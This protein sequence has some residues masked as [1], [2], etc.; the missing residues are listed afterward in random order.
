M[1]PSTS[2]EKVRKSL[3]PK[4]RKCFCY[5]S[6]KVGIILMAVTNTIIH[7]VSLLMLVMRVL[8]WSEIYQLKINGKLNITDVETLEQSYD[9]FHVF[10]T[11]V[12]SSSTSMSHIILT[13]MLFRG[14]IK[15]DLTLVKSFLIIGIFLLHWEVYSKMYF[16]T[17]SSMHAF[18]EAPFVF[19]SILVIIIYFFLGHYMLLMV[20]SY[21]NLSFEKLRQDENPEKLKKYVK[22]SN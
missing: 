6:L 10:V 20:N 9:F 21:L 17:V 11:R 13:T 19:M 14:L 16:L 4:P 2:K 8:K 15:S 3:L 22:P 12:A 18:I 1:E 5:V 7:I